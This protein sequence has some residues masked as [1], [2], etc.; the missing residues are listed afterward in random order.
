MPDLAIPPPP[1]LGPR[2]WPMGSYATAIPVAVSTR[3]KLEPGASQM[4]I[5]SAPGAMITAIGVEASSPRIWMAA[6]G[7]GFSTSIFMAICRDNFS[8]TLAVTTKFVFARFM[9]AIV[10]SWKNSSLSEVRKT[11]SIS[12]WTFSGRNSLQ[13][14]KTGSK[15]NFCP[16][17]SSRN[18]PRPPPKALIFM[19]PKV[20]VT[21]LAASASGAK[22]A[23]PWAASRALVA[24]PVPTAL[25]NASVAV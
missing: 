11:K 9:R 10:G 14:V 4:Y 12:L 13:S 18:E 6:S 5:P 19:P 22:A 17:I 23:S 24:R 16:F 8:A 20:A 2:C 7:P 25:P 15:S 1:P 3:T 21:L